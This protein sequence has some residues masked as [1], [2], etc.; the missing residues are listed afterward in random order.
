MDSRPWSVC[1]CQQHGGEK[2]SL[3]SKRFASINADIRWVFELWPRANR[4]PFFA[5][6]PIRTLASQA[7]RSCSHRTLRPTQP[8]HLL[9][10]APDL[11][12]AGTR[13]APFY[14]RQER[15]RHRTG[16]RAGPAHWR[17]ARTCAACPAASRT[18]WTRGAWSGTCS[19]SRC[20]GSAG[21]TAAQGGAPGSRTGSDKQPQ[22]IRGLASSWLSDGG[23]K[24]KNRR[25]RRETGAEVFLF[26]LSIIREPGTGYKRAPADHEPKHWGVVS[27]VG[28]KVSGAVNFTGQI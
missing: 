27:I 6:A 23:K 20:S 17:R 8:T 15:T 7:M 18:T 21:R 26:T 22:A 4:G 11:R 13:N 1:H 9:W 14:W 28:K 25:G 16:R 10:F 19:G 24:E 2:F 12:W 5:L 3:R